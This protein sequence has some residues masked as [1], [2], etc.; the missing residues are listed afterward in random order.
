MDINEGIKKLQEITGT[1]LIMLIV[2]IGTE[3]YTFFMEKIIYF[4]LAIFTGA[5]SET[6]FSFIT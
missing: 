2:F 3:D 1:K 5:E 6:I 4:L